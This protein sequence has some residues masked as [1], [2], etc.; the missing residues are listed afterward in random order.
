ML[1]LKKKPSIKTTVAPVS[2]LSTLIDE[3]GKDT[4]DALKK[5]VKIKALQ[6]ELKPYNAKLKILRDEINGLVGY[7]ADAEFVEQGLQF[8]VA[9]G[10]KEKKRLVRDMKALRKKIG[11]DVFFQIAKA[12]LTDIDKYVSTNE[13]T[14][15]GIVEETRGAR[16]IEVRTI[17]E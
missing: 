2:A 3:V 9:A 7:D 14:K 15:L 16:D 8:E 12:T 13:Q 5:I 10:K 4:A 6:E 17:R 1:V 11:D